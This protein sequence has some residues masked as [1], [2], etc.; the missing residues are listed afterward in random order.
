MAHCSQTNGKAAFFQTGKHRFM[1]EFLCKPIYV[2]NFVGE[3]RRRPEAAE[4]VGRTMKN[5][6]GKAKDIHQPKH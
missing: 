2:R 4:Q 6:N 5:R 3:I 1:P